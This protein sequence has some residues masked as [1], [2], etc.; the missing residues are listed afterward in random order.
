MN[1]IIEEQENIFTRYNIASESEDFSI[2]ADERTEHWET[3][4]STVTDLRQEL[5]QEFRYYLAV[6]NSHTSVSQR[7]RQWASREEETD[8]K[9]PDS[10]SVDSETSSL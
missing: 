6:E 4:N 7:L 5:K 9:G 3:M 8:E 2:P 1:E 10:E